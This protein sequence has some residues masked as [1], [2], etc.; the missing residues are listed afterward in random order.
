MKPAEVI[1]Q[2]GLALIALADL[3]ERD[4]QPARPEWYMSGTYPHGARAFR[5]HV[6][7]GMRA[8]RVGKSYRVRSEDAE[9]FWVTL[10]R[11]PAP[12]PQD[13]NSTPDRWARAGLRAVGGAP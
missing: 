8:I 9:A 4:P 6:H 13:I 7:L 3:Q 11:K 12:K 10:E 2:C 1:R 5:R